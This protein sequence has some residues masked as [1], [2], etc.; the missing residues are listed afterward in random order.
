MQCVD[1]VKSFPTHIFLQNLASM[2]PSTSPFKFARSPRTDPPGVQSTEP[3]TH[4]LGGFDSFVVVI[5]SFSVMLFGY[6]C[7][8]SLTSFRVSMRKP[9]ELPVVL[10]MTHLAAVAVYLGCGF[11][12]FY[13]FSVDAKANILHSLCTK[14]HRNIWEPDCIEHPENRMVYY[15]ILGGAV[16]VSVAVTLPFAFFVLFKSLSGTGRVQI[17]ARES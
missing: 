9:E 2:Q 6:C 11:A 12:G 1:L 7:S 13:G 4:M 3:W 17:R 5:K 14:G 16:V 8:D 15:Y 10:K